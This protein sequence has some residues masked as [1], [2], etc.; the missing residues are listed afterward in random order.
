MAQT[1]LHKISDT[2]RCP[3]LGAPLDKCH[4]FAYE[5]TSFD[6][7]FSLQPRDGCLQSFAS[8]EVL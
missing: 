4:K 5:K 7:E 3:P 6:D 2:L 8:N 1:R